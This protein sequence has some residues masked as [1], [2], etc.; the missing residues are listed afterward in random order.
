MPELL[1]LL[2]K[3]SKALRAVSEAAMRRHGLH[4]GQNFVLAALWEQDGR[5]PGE[6]AA[7]LHVTTPTVSKTA[8]RMTAGGHVTR[9]RDDRDNR[10]VRLWLTDS[11]RAL[12]QPVEAERRLIEDRI[13]ADLTPEE[14]THLL[15][16]LKKIHHT[17][18]TL[19]AP[20][21]TA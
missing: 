15:S 3:T 8:D 18:T 12:Q 16:A 19:A 6:L 21:P 7:A 17:S 9:R 5:T 2:S 20:P 14:R 1:D 4:D 10:L 13:T 11:G